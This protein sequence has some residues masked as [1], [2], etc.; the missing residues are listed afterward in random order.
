MST[1][2]IL[3]DPPSLFSIFNVD[4]ENKER[5]SIFLHK[6]KAREKE[7]NKRLRKKKERQA[8][9]PWF[10][11]ASVPLWNS[12]KAVTLSQCSAS[13]KGKETGRQREREISWV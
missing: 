12:E 9:L 11:P 10:P 7:I 3:P 5:G 8:T 4:A 1:L 6:N 13:N 2:V